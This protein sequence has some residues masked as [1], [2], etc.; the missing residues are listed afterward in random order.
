MDPVALRNY[1]SLGGFEKLSSVEHLLFADERLFSTLNSSD[2][3][4][5][6][7]AAQP[8]TG[9]PPAGW[10][11]SME[12]KEEQLPALMRGPRQPERFISAKFPD[13]AFLSKCIT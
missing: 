5:D 7:N 10:S 1:D 6:V 9:L 3:D 12:V 4:E 2:F 13:Y 8:S 11:A